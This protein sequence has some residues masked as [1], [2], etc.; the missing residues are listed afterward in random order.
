MQVNPGFD[1]VAELRLRVAT[2][3]REV[4]LNH[5]ILPA[6]LPGE[7]PRPRPG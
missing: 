6:Q 5:G 4:A 2:R 7:G 1:F 3:R